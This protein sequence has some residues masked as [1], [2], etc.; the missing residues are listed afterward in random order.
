[1]IVFDPV[2]HVILSKILFLS[3]L[4]LIFDKVYDKAHDK[5]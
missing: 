4:R 3:D 5:V 1:M 2:N